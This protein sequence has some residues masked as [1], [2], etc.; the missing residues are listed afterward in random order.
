MSDKSKKFNPPAGYVV[1]VHQN[2]LG[3][4]AVAQTLDIF[5][6]VLADAMEKAGFQLISDPFDLSA[7]A[8][9]VIRL[10]S[11]QETQGLHVVKE[12]DDDAGSDT[13]AD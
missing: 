11:Q 5:P 6:E 8:G 4:R 3:I 7:D 1:A 9:K 10:Q 2:V 12:G 13:S